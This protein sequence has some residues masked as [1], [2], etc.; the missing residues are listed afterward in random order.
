[1]REIY[2]ALALEMHQP[3][4]NLQDL[5]DKNEWEAKEILFAGVTASLLMGQVAHAADQKVTISSVGH[6]NIPQILTSS[7]L[8]KGGVFSTTSSSGFNATGTVDCAVVIDNRDGSHDII[9]SGST[10]VDRIMSA[11][12]TVFP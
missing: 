2:Y 3:S 10:A 7:A 1:M 12:I 8:S 5:V 4:G 6:M 9:L 11:G